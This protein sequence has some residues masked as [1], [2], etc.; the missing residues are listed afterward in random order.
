MSFAV[1]ST[2][3]PP[4]LVRKIFGL[5]TGTIAAR[6][7]ASSS[8]GRVAY[9]WND[10]YAASVRIWAAAASAISARPCPTLQYQSAAGASSMRWPD[11]SQ[12]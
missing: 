8:A 10:E 4:P 11:S 3:S 12:T 5:S 6:R 7:S 1:A 9:S 2:A